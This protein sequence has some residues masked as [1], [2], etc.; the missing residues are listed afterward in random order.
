MKVYSCDVLLSV[1]GQKKHEV[2]LILL[3]ALTCD[4]CFYKLRIDFL[5][6]NGYKH[7][8]SLIS[9]PLKI[10]GL[11]F[12][13]RTHTSHIILNLGEKHI[14]SPN[15]VSKSNSFFKLCHLGFKYILTGRILES[16]TGFIFTLLF[17]MT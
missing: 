11:L 5:K 3:L 9:Y 10:V 16:L 6:R 15:F 12:R 4:T 8:K 1:D 2:T 7:F 13:L 14:S 17:S